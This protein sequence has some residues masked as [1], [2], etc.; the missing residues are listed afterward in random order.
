MI[1]IYLDDV[2]TPVETEWVV[3]RNYEEFVKWTNELL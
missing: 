3:V 1:R 2:R